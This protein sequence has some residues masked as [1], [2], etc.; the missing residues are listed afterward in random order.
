MTTAHYR[1]LAFAAALVLTTAPALALFLG[2][3]S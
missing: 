3:A 2:R 1:L